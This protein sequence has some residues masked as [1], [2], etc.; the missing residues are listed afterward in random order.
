MFKVFCY[1]KSICSA[2][3]LSR[4]SER[5]PMNLELEVCTCVYTVQYLTVEAK[6]MK[7]IRNQNFRFCSRLIPHLDVTARFLLVYINHELHTFPGKEQ[8]PCNISVLNTT[9]HPGNLWS[10]ISLKAYFSH[11]FEGFLRFFVGRK[12]QYCS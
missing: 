11:C 10:R 9:R 3:K 7:R 6:H 8:L 4:T 12:S 5:K 1:S 2:R